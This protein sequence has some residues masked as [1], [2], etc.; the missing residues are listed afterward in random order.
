[1]NEQTNKTSHRKFPAAVAVGAVFVV[2]ALVG[3]VT[4]VS[5][6]IQLGQRLLDNSSKKE[7][8]GK[9]IFPVVMFDPQTIESPEE[10]DD[11]VL[12]RSS[13]WSAYINNMEKYTIDQNNRATVMA[14]DVDVACAKLFGSDITLEHQS[15]SDYINTYY[16]D[17]SSL[18]YLLPLDSSSVLYTPQVEDFSKSGVVY[19]LK[20]GYLPSGSEWMQLLQGEDYE[21]EPEKYMI[22]TV[23][24]VEDHYQLVSIA[25]PEE[26]AVPGKP[27]YSQPESTNETLPTDGTT[28]TPSENTT[29]EENKE[30]I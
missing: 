21:P 29:T 5:G 25:Y 13:I 19:T 7:E 15:F 10:L 28:T 26:G 3:L 27:V 24:K 18:S 22:Y 2:L 6:C 4:V 14:S 16:Y 17:E 12:L 20:V 8:L 9:A 23:M 11:L 30:T 1:M